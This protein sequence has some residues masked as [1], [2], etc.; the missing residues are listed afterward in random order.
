MEAFSP[1]A[2]DATTPGGIPRREKQERST[3][4]A[5]PIPVNVRFRRNMIMQQHLL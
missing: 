5:I 1:G 2:K 4:A 3:T